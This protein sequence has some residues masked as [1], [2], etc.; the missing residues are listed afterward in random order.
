MDLSD[1]PEKGGK[2]FNEYRRVDLIDLDPDVDS[3]E[4]G[5]RDSTN[6]SGGRARFSAQQIKVDLNLN[7]AS[8]SFRLR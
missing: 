5:Q 7:S 8:K 2:P 1:D 6:G 4:S 3:R